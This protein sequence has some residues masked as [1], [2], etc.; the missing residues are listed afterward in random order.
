MKRC[1]RCMEQYD[2]NLIVCPYCLYEEDTQP[3]VSYFLRPGTVIGNRYLIGEVI[4]SGGFGITYVGW[5][6]VLNLKVAIKEYF[7]SGVAS[8]E[9]GDT[10]LNITGATTEEFYREGISKFLEEARLIAAFR[11]QPNIVHIFNFLE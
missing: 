4:G 8:R 11:E 3:E 10:R 1:P 6:R 7:P 5:D 9:N 2:D